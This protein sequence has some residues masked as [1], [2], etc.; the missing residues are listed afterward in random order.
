M[1]P[2][3]PRGLNR[4]PEFYQRGAS[5]AGDDGD[6]QAPALELRRKIVRGRLV[7]GRADADTVQRLAALRKRRDISRKAVGLEV[8]HEFA[9]GRVGAKSTNLNRIAAPGRR[10]RRNFGLGVARPGVGNLRG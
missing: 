7:G 1:R 6:G 4:G 8:V 5:A 10:G 3:A 2:S 9:G